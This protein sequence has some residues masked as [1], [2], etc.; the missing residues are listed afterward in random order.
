MTLYD[1]HGRQRNERPG[2]ST[3]VSTSANFSERPETSLAERE[4]FEPP[5]LVSLPLSRR[6]HLSA[7]PPFRRRGY[8]TAIAA[9]GAIVRAWVKGSLAF[10]VHAP[11]TCPV[12]RRSICV[13][14]RRVGVRR[15]AMQ[16]APWWSP[17]HRCARVCPPLSPTRQTWLLLSTPTMVRWPRS[18]PA[19]SRDDALRTLGTYGTLAIAAADDWALRFDP[20]AHSTGIRCSSRRIS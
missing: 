16:K 3:Y 19:G 4:G 6:M 11:T 20:W 5:G 17:K 14:L 8:R 12:P 13:S 18:M 2:Q 10:G 9:V 1:A 15:T 7:L